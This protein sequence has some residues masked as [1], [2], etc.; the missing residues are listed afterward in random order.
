[1]P[2]TTGLEIAKY[3]D[4]LRADVNHATSSTFRPLFSVPPGLLEVVGFPRVFDGL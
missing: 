1:V 3:Y 4:G 2:D